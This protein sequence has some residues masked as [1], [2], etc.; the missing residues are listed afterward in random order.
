LWA[1]QQRPS[2]AISSSAC[3]YKRF[4][5]SSNKTRYTADL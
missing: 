4:A 1:A 3:K 2:H 5:S